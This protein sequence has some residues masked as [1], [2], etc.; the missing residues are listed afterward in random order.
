MPCQMIPAMQDS[1]CIRT[2]K[3]VG[4]SIILLEGREGLCYTRLYQYSQQGERKYVTEEALTC[5][6]RQF[7]CRATERALSLFNQCWMK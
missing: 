4:V 5:K 3:E 2:T 7:E 6:R 1:L